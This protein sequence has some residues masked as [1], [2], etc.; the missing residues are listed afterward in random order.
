MTFQSLGLAAELLNAVEQTGYTVPT[1]V[2]MLALDQFILWVHADSPY[3]TAADFLADTGAYDLVTM[4]IVWAGAYAENGYSV[5][6]TDWVARDAAELELDPVREFVG[7][8]LEAQAVTSGTVEG[9]AKRLAR[10]RN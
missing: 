5:D 10:R 7:R 9:V 8:D 1:P 4:D 6:L 3:K 2:Q